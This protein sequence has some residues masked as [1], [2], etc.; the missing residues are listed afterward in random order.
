MSLRKAHGCKGRSV[1]GMHD[2]VYSRPY[3]KLTNA[4][5]LIASAAGQTT[6]RLQ[7]AR[8]PYVQ[9]STRVCFQCEN[10]TNSAGA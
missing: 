7:V 1:Y 4:I 3:A 6:H 10:F 9:D 5:H 8:A 2:I